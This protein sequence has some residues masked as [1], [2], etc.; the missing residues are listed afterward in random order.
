VE[1]T[2][3]VIAKVGELS[4][5][6]QLSQLSLL[7]LAKLPLIRSIGMTHGKM[8]FKEVRRSC[9]SPSAG[10]QDLKRLVLEVC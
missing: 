9:L 2:E 8:R 7:S 5:L 4:Q 6:S 1:F 10:G 3:F